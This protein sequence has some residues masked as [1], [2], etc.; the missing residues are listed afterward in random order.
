MVESVDKTAVQQERQLVDDFLR[1]VINILDILVFRTLSKNPELVYS[2]LHQQ[3]VLLRLAEEPQ[4]NASLSNT[5]IVLK[6]FNAC[7]DAARK[8]S[9]KEHAQNEEWSVSQVMH[10]IQHELLSWKRTS[11]ATVEELQCTYEEAP[12]AFDFFLPYVWST[13]LQQLCSQYFPD[14]CVGPITPDC[15][16]EPS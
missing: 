1:N 7:V 9:R 2:I 5:I 10:V 15:K 13:V 8:S 12:R 3:A 16:S 6:H 11:L 4:W 14:P